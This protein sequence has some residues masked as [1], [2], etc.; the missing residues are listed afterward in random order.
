MKLGDQQLKTRQIEIYR[1][2]YRYMVILK[3]HS[4]H[5]PKIYNGYMGKKRK[6]NPNIT[7][8]ICIKSQNNRPKEKK[9]RPIKTT[10]KQLTTCDKM[11]I[12]I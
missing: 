7:L 1:Y 9:K 5:K 6:R 2:R 3:S 8:K 12:H 4:N 11:N 10:P